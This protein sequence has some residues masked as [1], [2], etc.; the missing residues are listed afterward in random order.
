MQATEIFLQ[1]LQVILLQKLMVGRWQV[2]SAVAI[3]DHETLIKVKNP[4]PSFEVATRSPFTSKVE[5]LSSATPPQQ[6]IDRTT[7]AEMLAVYAPGCSANLFFPMCAL[8]LRYALLE[9]I[10]RPP[11]FAYVIAGN[12]TVALAL[13]MAVA[14]CPHRSNAMTLS[15]S[16][17]AK[18][19]TVVA[20]SIILFGREITPN[21]VVA[22]TIV[23]GSLAF[24]A[25]APQEK[26]CLKGA[27]D[28][29]VNTNGKALER[30]W[31]T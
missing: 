9:L 3:G 11:L 30:G 29:G 21:F 18:D 13:N 31:K 15:L 16:G 22:M 20:V 26:S 17:W 5:A 12:V 6:G 25:Y 4:T 14:T 2:E 8:E 23:A 28:T 7:P 24:Y 27:G 1:T 10:K 19:W